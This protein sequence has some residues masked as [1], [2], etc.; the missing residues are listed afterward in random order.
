MLYNTKLSGYPE[1]TNGIDC[2]SGF[3]PRN[4][5]SRLEAAPIESL[6]NGNLGF[7]DK[8]IKLFSNK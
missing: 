1:R 5:L 8:Q 6:S 2:G 3:Q 4:Q 7:P